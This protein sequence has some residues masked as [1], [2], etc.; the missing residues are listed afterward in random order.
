MDILEQLKNEETRLRRQLKGIQGA[1]AALIGSKRAL[2][3]SVAVA[4]PKRVNRKRK[5]SAAARARI[6]KTTKERWARFRAEKT[7][8]AK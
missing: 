1:I 8:R 5:M 4:S 3:S 6:S 2:S 7:K